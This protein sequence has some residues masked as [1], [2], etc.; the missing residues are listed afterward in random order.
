M[1]HVIYV[2]GMFSAMCCWSI[3]RL[4]SLGD[5]RKTTADV[6]KSVVTFLTYTVVFCACGCTVWFTILFSDG[7]W[8]VWLIIIPR[9]LIVLSLAPC[10]QLH[11]ASVYETCELFGL[12]FIYV[13]H[14]SSALTRRAIS[15]VTSVQRSFMFC[16]LFFPAIF[17][18]LGCVLLEYHPGNLKRAPVFVIILKSWN[19]KDM[20]AIRLSIFWQILEILPHDDDTNPVFSLHL[21]SYYRCREWFTSI[22]LEFR[23]ICKVGRFTRQA[24]LHQTV[25]DIK[26]RDF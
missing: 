18:S 19:N 13:S 14:H 22:R 2:I 10:K 9:V 16:R 3:I 20:D 5:Y 21:I 24:P 7:C 1:C 8:H 17:Q 15:H 11:S 4:V 25:K 23:A 6:W 12:C 26:V